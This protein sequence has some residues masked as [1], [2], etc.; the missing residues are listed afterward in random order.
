MRGVLRNAFLPVAAALEPVEAKEGEQQQY[1]QNEALLGSEQRLCV[2]E[3]ALDNVAARSLRKAHCR[4]SSWPCQT[5]AC[6]TG[7]LGEG[8][9]LGEPMERAAQERTHAQT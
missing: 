5:V 6:R 8:A 1:R 2:V 7:T 4:Q 3:A 9:R